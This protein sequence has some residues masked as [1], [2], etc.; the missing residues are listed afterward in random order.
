MMIDISLETF[1][2]LTSNYGKINGNSFLDAREN[3]THEIFPDKVVIGSNFINCATYQLYFTNDT[4]H[5]TKYELDNPML[6]ESAK[7]VHGDMTDADQQELQLRWNTMVRDLKAAEKLQNSG[8]ARNTLAKLYLDIFDEDQALE[9]IDELPAIIK[10]EPAAVWEELAVALQNSGN[11]VEFEWSDLTD[12]GIYALNELEPLQLEGII[13]DVPSEEEYEEI[14][15]ADDFA[16]ASLEF[17]NQQ[18]KEHDLKIVAVGTALDE[19]QAFTC[20]SVADGKLTHALARLSEL[21]LV[22]LY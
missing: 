3:V 6:H 15:A 14:I 16:K 8:N 2:W 11:L 18:L 17:V 19:F 4:L 7:M 5:V 10:P 21:C 9:L 1:N 20:L 22:Y 12:T 13:L